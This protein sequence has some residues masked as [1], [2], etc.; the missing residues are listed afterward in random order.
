[1]RWCAGNGTVGEKSAR[2]LSAILERLERAVYG[3]G[4]TVPASDVLDTA[5][6]IVK[7]GL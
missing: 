4:A 3:G 7:E 6:R 5:D 2:E 1:M